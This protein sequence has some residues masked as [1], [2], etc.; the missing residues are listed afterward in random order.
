MEAVGAFGKGKIEKQTQ[1]IEGGNVFNFVVKFPDYRE[2]QRC[3]GKVSNEDYRYDE[4]CPCTQNLFIGQGRPSPIVLG[5]RTVQG[6]T[7]H[8]NQLCRTA[9]NLR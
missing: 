2:V 6:R 5:H 3:G 1:R 7:V 9:Q 8:S 4:K